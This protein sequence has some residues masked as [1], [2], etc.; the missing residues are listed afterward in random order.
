MTTRSEP[1]RALMLAIVLAGGVG[2]IWGIAGAFCLSMIES[3]L[4]DSG[5]SP[6][7][8]L[9]LLDDGT[10]VFESSRD[11]EET[12]YT[13]DGKKLAVVQEKDARHGLGVIK[14]G[15]V[16]HLLDVG[17]GQR[18][19][20]TKET[21][22]QYGVINW[23]E[24]VRAIGRKQGDWWYFC[25][26][27]GAPDHGYCVGFDSTTNLKVGYIGRN[28]FR[29]DVPPMGEQFRRT[30]RPLAV[31]GMV[32]RAE[33]RKS[34][35]PDDPNRDVWESCNCV[36]SDEGLIRIDVE[37][38]TAT[39]FRKGAGV[40]SATGREFS[41]WEGDGSSAHHPENL[42]RSAKQV[43]VLNGDGKEIEAYSLPAE[44][45][46]ADTE[47]FCFPRL[48]NVAVVENGWFTDDLYW[49]DRAGKIIRHEDLGSRRSSRP[50]LR[51]AIGDNIWTILVPSPAVLAV[52]S[53]TAQW[54]E[55]DANNLYDCIRRTGNDWIQLW[56]AMLILCVLAVILSVLC[57]RRQR[58]FGL[59]G[60]W[61]WTIFVLLFGLPAYFGY[62][63]HRKWP[64]RL[65]CPSCGKRVPR[66]RPACFACGRDFPAP[67]MK[68][69]EVFG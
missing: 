6:R 69:I 7:R 18:L 40:I 3:F 65:P 61:M 67:A 39:V 44:L 21:A 64:A 19:D 13:L 47:W 29:R 36:L 66:D 30:G 60:T 52:F 25:H 8:S 49:I 17:E 28:G 51:K 12:V 63:A 45:Q 41:D 43:L 4:P 56:P 2:V 32:C 58:K 11:D 1:L 34:K 14:N 15:A 46:T 24:R 35:R 50:S 48:S 38:R 5:K 33:Q 20:G 68:G 54:K 22:A 53:L 55:R 59:P 26:D 10:P 27:R 57:Y 42:V 31:V 62:L 9:A 16:R 23:S 37:R